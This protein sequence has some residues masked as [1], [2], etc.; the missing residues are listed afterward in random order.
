MSCN[1]GNQVKFCERLCRCRCLQEGFWEKKIIEKFRNWWNSELQVWTRDTNKAVKHILKSLSLWVHI[2]SLSAAPVCRYSHC[3]Y[4]STGSFENEVLLCF[5]QAVMVRT[6]LVV[7]LFVRLKFWS[8]RALPPTCEHV[9]CFVAALFSIKTLR[10]KF[11]CILMNTAGMSLEVVLQLKV[12]RKKRHV[13][14]PCFLNHK[15]TSWN[16]SIWHQVKSELSHVAP[17]LKKSFLMT[18]NK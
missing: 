7:F 9:F 12:S 6:L 8:L 1:R 16:A 5:V 3:W 14:W 4:I 18:L 15:R 11:W 2:S 13:L 10:S 17:I